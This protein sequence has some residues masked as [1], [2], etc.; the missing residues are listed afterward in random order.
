MQVILKL[1]W[2][3]ALTSRLSTARIIHTSSKY[4]GYP[5]DLTEMHG[6]KVSAKK[7]EIYNVA[8]DQWLG[9]SRRSIFDN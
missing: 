6:P 2:R 4:F 8:A 1:Q 9:T 7:Y 3:S 5:L